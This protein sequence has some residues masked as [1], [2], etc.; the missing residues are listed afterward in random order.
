MLCN[1][2]TL[3]WVTHAHARASAYVVAEPDEFSVDSAMAP[4]GVLWG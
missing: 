2:R 4:G 3:R 1:R